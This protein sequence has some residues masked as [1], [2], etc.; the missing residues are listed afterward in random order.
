[1]KLCRSLYFL[2]C[3]IEHPKKLSNSLCSAQ[4]SER[5]RTKPVWHGELMGKK[6]LRFDLPARRL[7]GGTKRRFMNVV[8][9]AWRAL[10]SEKMVQ[11]RGSTKS[12]W[13]KQKIPFLC[14]LAEESE[15]DRPFS[16]YFLWNESTD[17]LQT[18]VKQWFS[19]YQTGKRVRTFIL[20]PLK[21]SYMLFCVSLRST[22]TKF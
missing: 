18:N 3:R 6:M 17:D 15:Q 19:F 9:R 16:E 22:V 2:I 21:T 11:R 20:T 13:K 10:M 8:L 14:V 7:R 1:M 4:N 5:I 12:S